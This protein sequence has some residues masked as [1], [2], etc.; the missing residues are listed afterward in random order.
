MRPIWKVKMRDGDMHHIAYEYN[1]DVPTIINE[2]RGKGQL[3]Q[4]ERDSTPT[5][6]MIW[7]D[8][9]EVQSVKVDR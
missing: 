9:D 8:P 3:I 4:L 6:Q 2:A 5:G 1:I 7:I